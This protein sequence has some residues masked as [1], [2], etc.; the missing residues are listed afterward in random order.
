M[1]SEFEEA[2]LKCEVCGKKIKVIRRIGAETKKFLC[3][4]CMKKVS[5]TSN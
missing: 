2:E 3:Q 5:D 4:G 1:I